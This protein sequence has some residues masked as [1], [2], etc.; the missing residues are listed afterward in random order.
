MT[1]STQKELERLREVEKTFKKICDFEKKRWMDAYKGYLPFDQQPS[2]KKCDIELLCQE[3]EKRRGEILP[4]PFC[5]EEPSFSMT[6]DLYEGA[7]PAFYMECSGCLKA[8][9]NDGWFD[10]KTC[11]DQWNTRSE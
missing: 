11:I 9:I 1:D 3:V 6:I 2:D 8:K 4:C 5:G 10:I 7:S